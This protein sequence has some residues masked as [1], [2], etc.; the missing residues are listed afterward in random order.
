LI[1]GN[2]NLR[3]TQPRLAVSRIET[4]RGYP[5]AELHWFEANGI[6]QRK[7]RIKRFLD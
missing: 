6:G 2:I 5:V 7:I 1:K 3:P 4:T